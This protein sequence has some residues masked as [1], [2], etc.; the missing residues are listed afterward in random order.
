MSL[1]IGLGCSFINGTEAGGEKYSFLR[2]LGD[3]IKAK[4]YNLGQEGS[5][6]FIAYSKLYTESMPEVE[7]AVDLNVFWMPTGI[8]R[9][10]VIYGDKSQHH[11]SYLYRTAFPCE[12]PVDLGDKNLAELEKTLWNITHPAGYVTKFCMIAQMIKTWCDVYRAKLLIFPAFSRDLNRNFCREVVKGVPYME[13]IVDNAPWD[14]FINVDGCDNFFD[15]TTKQIGYNGKT[16]EEL[17]LQPLP[18][19]FK[20]I[21][22]ERYHPLANSHKNFANR[23]INI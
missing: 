1:L 17:H 18:T 11:P 10:E 19:R 5:S 6:N 8:N 7:S 16:M 23:L 9:D 3:H 22:G 12:M 4:V 14:H 20:H 15:W 13:R 2:Y 21:L